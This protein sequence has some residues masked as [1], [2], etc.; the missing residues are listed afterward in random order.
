MQT[1]VQ[2]VRL[3][4]RD[5]A[6]QN[7]DSVAPMAASMAKYFASETACDVAGEAVQIHGG[8]GYTKDFDVERYY[9]DAKITTIYEGTTNIQKDIIARHLRE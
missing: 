2:A 9:R 6:R 1:Q 7:E 8:Y 4:S 5:A 3:L